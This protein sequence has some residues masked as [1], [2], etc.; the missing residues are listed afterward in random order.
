MEKTLF[1]R[2]A[3]AGLGT[4]RVAMAGLG[5][6]GLYPRIMSEVNVSTTVRMSATVGKCL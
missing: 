5:S 6:I 1:F 2:A 3:M 4:T